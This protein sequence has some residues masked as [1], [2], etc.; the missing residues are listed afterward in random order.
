MGKGDRKTR[1]GK[2]YAGSFGKSRPKNPAKH[3]AKN[4]PAKARTATR[5]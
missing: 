2:I 1:R 4:A 3:K 5:K